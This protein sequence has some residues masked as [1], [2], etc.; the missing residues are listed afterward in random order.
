ML[1]IKLKRVY[2]LYV[3]LFYCHL[4]NYFNKHGKFLLYLVCFK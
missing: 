1:L 3:Y 2:K 4:L